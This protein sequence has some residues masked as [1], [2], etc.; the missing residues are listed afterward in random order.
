MLSMSYII[1]YC[2]T[3][4]QDSDRLDDHL[5][6]FEYEETTDGRSCAVE[7]ECSVRPLYGGLQGALSVRNTDFSRRILSQQ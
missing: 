2:R 6:C 4:W 1:Q 5:I 3:R 7:R